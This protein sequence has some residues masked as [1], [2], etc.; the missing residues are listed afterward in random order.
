MIKLSIPDTVEMAIKLPRKRKAK[1]AS[2]AFSS[3]NV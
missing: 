3:K 1:G 2:K